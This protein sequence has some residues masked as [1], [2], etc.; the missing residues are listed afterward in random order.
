[1]NTVPKGLWGE[2]P[3]RV[4]RGPSVHDGL[5][6]AGDVH[7]RGAL[8]G[9]AARVRG[10]R[11]HGTRGARNAMCASLLAIRVRLNVLTS[12]FESAEAC[13]VH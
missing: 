1:M 3:S 2:V 5:L 9:R 7:G 6:R 13:C 10:I 8:P 4:R 12:D 11:A